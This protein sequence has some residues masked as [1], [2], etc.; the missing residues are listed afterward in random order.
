[1]WNRD[2]QFR[3]LRKL[4]GFLPS[5][6]K[7]GRLHHRYYGRSR[8]QRRAHDYKR[9]A[10]GSSS[11]GTYGSGHR[12]RQRMFD[13]VMP[14]E[15]GAVINPIGMINIADIM[16]AIKKLVFEEKKYTLEELNTA[17]EAD[18]KGYE[19]M[20]LDFEHAPKYGND[21]DFVD[22]IAVKWFADFCRIVDSK[23][24]IY[25]HPLIPTGISITS[26]Q[27]GGELTGATPDG[28]HAHEI[29]ADGSVSPMHGMDTNGPTAVMNSAKKI[30]QD[31]F[32]GD[33]DEHEV[34]SVI[35]GIGRGS[36]E[37]VRTD[38]NLSRKRRKACAVQCSGS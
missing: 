11:L 15:N 27:P 3:S 19:K 25:D 35:P 28:R 33:S 32:Q 1:M 30:N 23:K 6:F 21:N 31:P 10:A 18:W 17:L 36:A 5:V 2:R 16:A 4:R 24:T 37:T 12:I 8:V 7:A 22:E 38:S 9:A 34:Y 29:L 13:R 14:F 26:H 20:R